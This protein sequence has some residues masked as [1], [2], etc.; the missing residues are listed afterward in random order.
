MKPVGRARAWLPRSAAVKSSVL[1]SYQIRWLGVLLIAAQLAQAVHLP[2]WVGGFGLVLVALRFALLSRDRWRP[3]SP[4]A[5]IPSW[6]LALFALAMAVAIRRSYGYFFARDPCVAFLYLL[7]GIKFLEARTARDGTLL[8]C[9]ASFLLITPFFYS[10]SLLAA[11]AA[12]PGLLLLGATLD[13]L[14]RPNGDLPVSE[15]RMAIRRS[16]LIL[17]QGVPI[18]LVLFVMFPRLSGPLWGLPAD[19]AAKTGLSDRMSPGSVSELSL[20]DDVAFRVDFD[21][22]V[23]PPAQRY[24]RGPVLSMFNGRDWTIAPWNWNGRLVTPSATVYRYTVTLEPHDRPWLFALDFPTALPRPGAGAEQAR[25]APFLVGLTHDQ[26]IVTRDPVVQPLRYTVQ[27]SV[28]DRYPVIYQNEIDV[29]RA[30]PPGN[31]RMTQFATELRAKYP[32]DGDYVLAVLRYFRD[33]PFTYTLSPALL[34]DHPIDEFLFDTRRGFCEHF[35]SAFVALMRAGGIP[36]RVVTGYQGGQVNPAGDYLI[37]RQ[38]DAHAWAEVALNGEWVR[39]DPTAAVAPNRIEGGLGA[40]LPESDRVPLFA[41]LQD[42]WYKDL[43]L[44]WDALNHRWRRYVIDFNYARQRSFWRE[45]RLDVFAAWQVVVMVAAFI[46]AWT[47]LVLGWLALRRRRQERAL[48]LW[49]MVCKR[50]AH[51]GMPRMPYEGPLAF[52]A[53]AAARWPQFAIAFHAIGESFA[54]LRYGVARDVERSALLDTLERA[55][56]VLPGAAALRAAAPGD[57]R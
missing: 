50:L 39:M 33:E 2:I 55:I 32:R 17:L 21:G 48:A 45:W 5:R 7:I 4:P 20:S 52:A 36:A 31:P 43:Q 27:S 57:R 34:G 1:T 15:W 18:A 14:A 37:V 26:R 22:P 8:V 30:P 53:R 29:N 35:S 54:T 51:A 12:A 44:S 25:G 40:A 11:A 19:H 42:G 9:L 13:S 47:G 6:A 24:W 16:G 38:S 46:G 49:G 56:E 3:G 23:P 41:R 10:Q 28:N